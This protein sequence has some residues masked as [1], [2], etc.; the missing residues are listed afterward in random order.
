MD[1]SVDGRSISYWLFGHILFLYL[2]K[3]EEIHSSTAV[4]RPPP[5]SLDPQVGLLFIKHF[6]FS[7][8]AK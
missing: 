1:I 3:N 8:H 5:S 7:V 4:R 6:L 2:L